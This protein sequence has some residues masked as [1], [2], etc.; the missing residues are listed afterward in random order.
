MTSMQDDN[1]RGNAGANTNANTNISD[2]Q[3]PVAAKAPAKGGRALSRRRRKRRNRQLAA[4]IAGAVLALALCGLLAWLLLSARPRLLIQRYPMEYVQEI[5]ENA[6]SNDIPPAYVA[7][8]ILAESSYRPDA[9]SYADARGLMQLL[10][11]TAEWVCEKL[12]E[13][14]LEE[15]LWVP[16]A[17]IRYGSWYLG[18]L[19]RLFDGDMTCATAAYHAG[20]GRVKEWLANPEY[21]ADG[22]TLTTIPSDAT[23]T[24]VKR[25]L[26]YYEKYT[27][28][29]AKA[30]A[31]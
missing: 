14:F 26:K 12:E 9:V 18:Y 19:M 1:R 11:S 24:Y 21:S 2:E 28:L 7:A 22:A 16:E 8:V 20:Q 13:P 30:E 17:N 3:T 23:A 29:Y 6:A 4:M 27:K 10:P 25:V 15:N 5:R 31:A